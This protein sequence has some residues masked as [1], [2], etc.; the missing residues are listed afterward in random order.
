MRITAQKRRGEGKSSEL[1]VIGLVILAAVYGYHQ[2]NRP[3]KPLPRDGSNS[4][5][6]P[7]FSGGATIDGLRLGVCVDTEYTLTLEAGAA[8]GKGEATVPIARIQFV[9]GLSCVFLPDE[10]YS[11][12]LSVAIGEHQQL[13]W[14]PGKGFSR[15]I[16]VDF[17]T[18]KGRMIFGA[19]TELSNLIKLP[20]AAVGQLTLGKD[21]LTFLPESTLPTLGASPSPATK[22]FKLDEGGWTL[23]PLSSPWEQL[24]DE[25]LTQA[26]ETAS[27]PLASE[28]IPH[29]LRLSFLNGCCPESGYAWL[30]GTT[31]FR[32]AASQDLK[33][34]WKPG[35]ANPLFAHIHT[36]AT[37]GAWEP[38]PGY[39]WATDDLTN[40]NVARQNSLL[41]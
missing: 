17:P 29:V 10:Q 11:P 1:A 15:D 16:G 31:G 12:T 21:G 26:P 35:L 34:Q 33:V 18:L 14:I 41:P 28:T 38:D 36:A 40:L 23:K 13:T 9:N 39:S 19:S 22:L 2:W 30:D 20:A 32:V 24:R 4:Y 3:A 6:D 7:I 37:E 5:G 25:K 8:F 27:N